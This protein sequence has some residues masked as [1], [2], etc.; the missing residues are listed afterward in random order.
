[1]MK[2]VEGSDVRFEVLGE[3]RGGRLSK[4]QQRQVDELKAIK[5]L[6]MIVEEERKKVRGKGSG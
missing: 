3:V 6:E 1:M 4:D 5:R 2:R